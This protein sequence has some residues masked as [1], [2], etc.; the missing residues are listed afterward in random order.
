MAVIGLILFNVHCKCE[1]ERACIAVRVD[2]LC[3]V[4]VLHLPAGFP[5]T[6]LKGMRQWGRWRKEGGWGASINA[7]GRFCLMVWETRG[8]ESVAGQAWRMWQCRWRIEEAGSATRDDDERLLGGRERIPDGTEQARF[9]TVSPL[10]IKKIDS[11]CSLPQSQSYEESC[12]FNDGFSPIHSFR[13]LVFCET[14]IDALF[15]CYEPKSEF[16]YFVMISFLCLSSFLWLLILLLFSV[17]LSYRPSDV[18]ALIVQYNLRRYLLLIFSASPVT[19]NANYL[20][21]SCFVSK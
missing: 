18:S 21:M 7:Y 12:S 20:Q 11:G 15:H 5:L 9:D 14:F 10:R 1:Y 6:E 17:C 4:A 13:L 8:M 16:F 3:R 19:A 2:C